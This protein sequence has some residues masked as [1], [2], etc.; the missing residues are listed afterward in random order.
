M[1][2]K[3]RSSDNKRFAI[4]NGLLVKVESENQRSKEGRKLKVLVPESLKAFVLGQH[5]NLELAAHQG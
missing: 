1:F 5:H 3:T 2:A 4:A